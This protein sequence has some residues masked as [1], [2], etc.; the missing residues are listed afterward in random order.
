MVAIEESVSYTS[1]VLLTAAA[2]LLVA[3][4]IQSYLYRRHFF[5]RLGI[6]GPRPHL[7]KGNGDEIRDH[8]RL[9]IDVMDQWQS[10]YGDV[11]GYYVGLKPYVVV[12]DLDLVQQVLIK[13]FHNFVNRPHMGIE[14]RPVIN[15]L[16]GLRDQ[17]WKHVRRIIS[18]TFS[19]S[20]MRMISVIINRCVDVLVEVVGKQQNQEIDFYG[21]F[22]GLTCQVIGR[23]ALDTEIDCQRN[24]SDDFL[25]ALRN[26]LKKANNPIIDLAIYFPIV[27]QILALICHIASPCGQF[28]Q[29]IIDKVQ[30]VIDTRRQMSAVTDVYHNDILQLL[31]DAAEDDSEGNN[32]TED[33][34]DS[35]RNVAKYLLSDDEII[36]NAWVFL[37]G[38]FETTANALTYCSYLLA[39]HP[40]IQD[41]VYQ[42]LDDTFQNDS[43]IDYDRV[44]QLTYLDQVFCEALRMFP[45]VVMF[46][47]REAAQDTQI[48][49]YHIPAGT[50]V[51]IPVWQIH[52]DPNLWPE[53]F[54]F[55]PDRFHPE[56][57]KTFHPMA[58]I[59]FGS[60]PRSCIGI[61]FALLEAKIA[62]ARL[63]I[64]FRLVPGDR[65]ETRLQLSVPTV[66][67][68]PKNPVWLK[69]EQRHR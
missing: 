40:D 20:K 15:T 47:T 44:S 17:R 58:W 52:H 64:N 4:L 32:N 16:V 49:Q 33:Q 61:R 68:N 3:C 54:H 43:E 25:G 57:R 53:P 45:P 59:P 66:T 35:R 60:G 69:V 41:R 1:G 37:L 27:R 30:K 65:T 63:L 23:A 22:Q 55:D 7:I 50:N 29:S 10:Q 31:L 42:E 12:K 46:V 14:I 51:Q 39:T 8:S 34:S 9:A 38:G 28:T 11:Y 19:K 56:L 18:P 13:D 67:L 48:G 21:L 6:P 5:R 24:T 36:A 26:F 2:V 62:L